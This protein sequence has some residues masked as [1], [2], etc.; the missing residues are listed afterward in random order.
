MIIRILSVMMLL[1]AFVECKKEPR[2]AYVIFVSGDDYING[3]VALAYQI[4]KFCFKYPRADM[5]AVHTN[6]VSYNTID[7]LDR[8]GWNCKPVDIIYPFR[9]VTFER[10][11]HT[12]TKL[13]LWSLDT[14]DAILYMDCDVVVL[15]RIDHL[16][17]IMLIHNKEDQPV[18]DIALVTD[19]WPN[20]IDVRFNSGVMLLRPSY[21][22]FRAMSENG[23]Y[24]DFESSSE[25]D[26]LNAWFQFNNIRLPV[27]YNLNAVMYNNSYHNAWQGAIVDCRML[28][29]TVC[30]PMLHPSDCDE[31]LRGIWEGVWADVKREYSWYR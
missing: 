17:D 9:V 26:F 6:T 4:K 22:V 31:G 10:F 1:P 30:K 23:P 29:Y 12:Y 15:G 27:I 2:L 7:V 3:A 14:Y 18:A 25:Q 8:V 24:I 13:W 20:E 11:K 16:F 19:A 21:S 5:I 28:H